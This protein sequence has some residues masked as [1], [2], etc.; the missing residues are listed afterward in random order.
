MKSVAFGLGMF[1]CGLGLVGVIAISSVGSAQKKV[2]PTQ[3][4]VGVMTAR[5]RVHS[6]LFGNYITGRA[7]D[8]P[9]LEKRPGKEPVEA[10]EDGVYLGPGITVTSPDVPELSFVD[11]L[12]DMSC[13]ADATVIASAKDGASQLTENR[14]FLFTDYIV[15]VEEN[16]KNNASA[17]IAPNS[18][19]TVTRPGGRVQIKGRIVSA[20]DSSFMPLDTGKRYLLFLKYV[21]ETGAYRSLRN[22]S[23]LIQNDD[24]IALTEETIPG[25]SGDTRALTAE[26]RRVLTSGC[27]RNK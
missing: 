16:L 6:K 26:V 17:Y 15:T 20:V 5:Q 22:G 7:L 24:L 2:E 3:I 23:F 21:P 25:G 18:D 10:T 13:Q 9:R 12:K 1:L 19:M 27:D 4:R 8:V 11:F 14:E